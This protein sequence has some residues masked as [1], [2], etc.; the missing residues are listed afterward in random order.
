MMKLELYRDMEE[1]KISPL[2]DKFGE[3][4]LGEMMKKELRGKKLTL[5]EEKVTSFKTDGIRVFER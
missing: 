4:A 2:K 5:E 1:S 3:S